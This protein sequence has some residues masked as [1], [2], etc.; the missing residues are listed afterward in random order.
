MPQFKVDK[1]RLYLQARQYLLSLIENGTYQPGERLPPEIDLAAQL[2]VSRPTL[3]EALFNLERE[4][5]VVRRHGVGTFVASKPNSRLKGG[6]GRL[7]SVLSLAARQGMVAQVRGLSVEQVLADEEL[8]ERLD[9]TPEMPLTR[10]QRT[11]VVKNRPIAY[12]IDYFSVDVISPGEL[13]LFFSGSIL[14]L[15]R[16]REDV[17][18]HEAVAQISAVNADVELADQLE[19]EPGQALLLLA[20]TL[21]TEDNQPIEFSHNYFLPDHF[22][23]HVLRR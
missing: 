16:Q 10:V 1:T 18:V 17:R 14:D 22:Q 19:I 15:L 13:G 9:V 4:G 12:L 8:A 21:F 2:G 11:I 7:E 6:L 23:F 20:E 3:R 5:V